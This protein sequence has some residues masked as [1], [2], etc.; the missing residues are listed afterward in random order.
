MTK[1]LS[2]DVIEDLL[3][4]Y[5]D[6]LT[7]KDTD[8]LIEEHIKNCPSCRDLL[9]RMKEEPFLEEVQT[10]REVDYLKDIRRHTRKKILL[11]ALLSV[12]LVMSAFYVK[13]FVIG[14]P[15]ELSNLLINTEVGEDGLLHIQAFSM[16]S[17]SNVKLKATEE[18]GQI[19]L[20]AR[21]VLVNPLSDTAEGTLTFSKDRVNRVTFEKDFTL[22]QDGIA[23]DYHTN[24]LLSL[25]T[26]YVGSAPDVGNLIINLD[27]DSP[28]TLELK[29]DQKPYG[30]TIH[31]SE[32]IRE[33]RQYFFRGNAYIVLALID[34]LDQ[35]TWTDPTGF[36]ETLTVDMANASLGELTA[37]YNAL[38]HTDCKALTSVKD[39]AEDS[40]ALQIL[41]DILA[42]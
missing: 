35:V 27:L 31:F 19:D 29:T 22:W 25:K 3:P 6:G 9:N 12:L 33:E 30:L 41:R 1:N 20:E 4:S 26:P 8:V 7:H 10:E 32:K 24:R 38:Y 34:N 17:A 21:T 23:V 40:V 18:D 14:S 28:R 15:A 39:Y 42:V 36:T 5:L 11:V 13:L 16:D 37:N 2:C